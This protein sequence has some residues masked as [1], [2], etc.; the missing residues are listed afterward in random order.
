MHRSLVY[1]YRFVVCLTLS[2]V[3]LYCHGE[4][5]GNPLETKSDIS[6]TKQLREY[7]LGG[8]RCH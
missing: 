3:S 7:V 2:T 8:Y 4:A 6:R 5:N 1:V